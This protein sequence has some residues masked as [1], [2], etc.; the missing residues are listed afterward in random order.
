[1]TA[2]AVLDITIS[3]RSKIAEKRIT[4]VEVI[5]APFEFHVDWNGTLTATTPRRDR[6]RLHNSLRHSRPRGRTAVAPSTALGS[7]GG[8]KGSCG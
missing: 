3:T 7:G 2:S 5:V 4:V 6:W 8:S 1:M